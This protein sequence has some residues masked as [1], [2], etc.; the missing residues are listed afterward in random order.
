MLLPPSSNILYQTVQIPRYQRWQIYHRLQ[1]LNIPC[2]C[3]SDGT[4]Q[5]QVNN[6]IA[7]ILLRSIVIQF[8]ASRPSLINWLER[9][10]QF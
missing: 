5:V 4:L 10:W 8:T 6:T 3:L 2:S 1:E 9:C 7:A